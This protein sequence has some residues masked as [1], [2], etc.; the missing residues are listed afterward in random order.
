MKVNL[1]HLTFGFLA[2]HVAAD[3]MI[4]H[5]QDPGSNAL[6]FGQG[7]AGTA[8]TDYS[9]GT[10]K[11]TQGNSGFWYSLMT[12]NEQCFDI[13]AASSLTVDVLVP[14]ADNKASMNIKIDIAND[15][16]T[17]AAY[18]IYQTVK[19]PKAGR[20]SLEFPIEKFYNEDRS[21]DK[22]DLKKIY[23]VVI[24]Q[25]KPESKAFEIYSLSWIGQTST[26]RG[27]NSLPQN[28]VWGETGCKPG[29]KVLFNPDFT[30]PF[31]YQG[32]WDTGDY[33]AGNAEIQ[34]YIN[35]ASTIFTANG[36]LHIKTYKVDGQWFSGRIRSRQGW[37][38][39]RVDST[40][41]L[42][43][44]CDGAFP[45]IWMLPTGYLPWPYAGE[46][47]IAEFNTNFYCKTPTPQS[48]HFQNHFGANAISNQDCA[49]DVTNFNTLSVEV[50][51]N[52]VRFY[53]NGVRNGGYT[54][55]YP[56]TE[57]MNSWP[58]SANP[59]GLVLNYAVQPGFS[60]PVPLGVYSMQ[61]TVS[62]L[63]VTECN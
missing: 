13:S 47:D 25:L 58:F 9:Q 39:F 51:E 38:N 42:D 48:L 63:E 15:E 53:C 32:E 44:A 3:F 24:N 1:K 5:F 18:S 40:F 61:M 11:Y 19:I 50:V 49:I 23:A 46:I 29:G 8:T 6:G 10:M 33:F 27:V 54:R 30:Q 52:E 59:F 62:R 36:A 4:T 45:A 35:D 37:K 34:K 17:S 41:K 20:Y 55:P 14:K 31:N 57:D 43:Q 22:S 12:G 16:C 60:L 2:N 7:A 56:Y 26:R 21:F 28:G